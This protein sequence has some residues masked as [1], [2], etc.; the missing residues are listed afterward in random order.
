MLTYVK[1]Y[2]PPACEAAVAALEKHWGLK[3]PASY[4]AFLMRTNGG[5][6]KECLIDFDAPKLRLQGGTLNHFFALAEDDSEGLAHMLKDFGDGIPRGMIFIGASPGGDY[7][8]LSLRPQSY[9]QVFY[10][11]HDF[12]D[13]TETDEAAGTLPES[14]VKIADSFD[15]FMARLYDPDA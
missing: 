6:P 3:L 10:K 12:E 13:F 2:A 8:L 15:D 7:F 9:G 11:D 1:T 4:R 5:Q 14:T